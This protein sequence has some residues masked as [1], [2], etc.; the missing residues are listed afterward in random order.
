[1]KKKGGSSSAFGELGLPERLAPLAEAA[2]AFKADVDDGALPDAMAAIV[3]A[4]RDVHQQVED[5]EALAAFRR[6][7]ERRRGRF[8][9]GSP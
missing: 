7:P 9:A 8:A 1:M 4:E 5:Q 6:S 2:P 3:P